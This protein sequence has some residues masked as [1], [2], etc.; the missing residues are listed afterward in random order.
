[1]QSSSFPHVSSSNREQEEHKAPSQTLPPTTAS[2]AAAAQAAFTSIDQAEDSSKVP[3]IASGVKRLSSARNKQEP[4]TSR[5][6]D[7]LNGEPV[8]CP[9]NN[10]NQKKAKDTLPHAQI[11]VIVET[12]NT[13]SLGHKFEFQ[14]ID[15]QMWVKEQKLFG[16]ITYFTCVEGQ[17]DGQATEINSD[18]S[19]IKFNYI[20]NVRQG[21]ATETRPDGTKIE[22]KY[23]NGVKQGQA[24]ETRSDGTKIK[25]NYV[26][27]VRQE[28]SKST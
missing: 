13:L 11:P 27:G 8:E 3:S 22:F 6:E 15:D 2:A 21:E 1:M 28:Q 9:E 10:N 17:R 20:N 19:K 7:E 4:S 24:T 16:G 18:G 12:F 25:I 5:S 14:N 23:V 26:Q